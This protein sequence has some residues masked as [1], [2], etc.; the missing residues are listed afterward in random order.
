MNLISKS[1]PAAI[2]LAMVAG[3]TACSSDEWKDVD[4]A[5]PQLKLT[6]LHERSEAGRTFKIE[7]DLSDADGIKTIEIV[8]HELNL[9]KCIDLID[10]YGEPQTTYHLDYSFKLKEDEKGESFMIDVITTDIGGR[11]D[12]QQIKLTLDGDFTAPVFTAAPDKTMTVILKPETYLNLKFTVS[13]NHV[14]DYVQIDLVDITDGTDNA[15]AVT[16][17]PLRVDGNGQK[18]I[19][20]AQRL[21]L[22][23]QA[24]TLQCTITAYDK[25]DNEAAHATVVNSTITVS[26]MPDLD[27]MYLCDVATAEELNS[28]VFGVPVAMDHVGPY[29]YR[30]RYYNEKPGT[31]I[32]FLAQRTDFGPICFAPDK[33]DPETMGDDPEDVGRIKL[34]QGGVYYTIDLNTKDRSYN[35]DTYAVADAVNPVQNMHYGQN[36]LNTWWETDPAKD[37]DIWW[38]EWWF[39]PTGGPNGDNPSAVPH[40]TQDSKNPNLYILEDWNLEGGSEMNFIL[41]NWHSDGWW[42]FT[43]WRVDDSQSPSKFMYYGNYIP[44]TS[45][46][47]SNDAYFNYKYIN[48]DKDEYKFQYPD[49]GDFDLTQWGTEG[50]RKN[51]VPDNWAKPVVEKTGKYKLIFDAHAERARLVPQN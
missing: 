33:N 6:T 42:N 22:P 29:K 50:Y 20:F 36:D 3:L 31:E 30:V 11:Q 40:M 18:E 38:Q 26:E 48:V 45:H 25:E 4:G 16:G 23:G 47:K 13:D 10:I 34:D 46:Y 37:G 2:A 5:A 7:G 28:D 43:T 21:S 8:C 1:L 17:F 12:K 15:P 39:G 14:M 35:L 24:A 51:F 41:H 9:N 32:C 19:N 27:V 44:E 49:A